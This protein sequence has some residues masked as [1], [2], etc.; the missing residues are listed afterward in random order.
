[1]I[2]GS[3]KKAPKVESEKQRSD[4]QQPTIDVVLDYI[5]TRDYVG[6]S[7]YLSFLQHDLNQ[8]IP[9]DIK[10]WEGYSLFHAGQ[11]EDAI[12]LYQSLLQEDPTDTTLNL[13]I[14]SCYFYL[15]EYDNARKFAL[16]GPECDLQT[17]LIFHIAQQRNDEEELLQ[18]HGKLVGTLENQLSLA[19]IHYQHNNYS[20]ALQIYQKILLQKPEYQAMNVYMA[21]CEFKLDQF[22]ESNDHVD[23]YLADNSDSA[24]A[25]NLKACDYFRLFDPEI[26]ESQL[27]QIHKFASASYD[28][29]S[30]L[31]KHNL[32]IFHNGEEGFSILP[33]ISSV[34]PEARYNLG[35]LYMR[36]DEPGEA[37]NLL[38]ENPTEILE[39]LLRGAALLANGQKEQ[40][41]DQV[42]QA[43][44]LFTETGNLEDVKDTVS[45]RTALST[46]AF[47]A[48]NY[49][50]SIS[51]LQT[52]EEYIGT[53]D[54]YKYNI[55]MAYAMLEKWKEAENYLVQVQNEIFTKD[56]HYRSALCRAMI[57][58]GK[59]D[60][61]W[62]MYVNCTSM[63]DSKALLMI[64]STDCYQLSYFYQSMRAF[65]V[66]SKTEEDPI[67]RSGL[68]ASAV[69]VFRS[70]LT[71]K[72][73][74]AHL[75]DVLGILSSEPSAQQILNTIQQYVTDDDQVMY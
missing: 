10:L 8:V 63:E 14:S 6:A 32:C 26:A 48:G 46:A 72:E 13:Y 59:P 3:K 71:Q 61:A 33:K 12:S 64:I 38:S 20:D 1:M 21:M 50:D 52:V 70:V 74:A 73:S 15:Q 28:F 60:D 18:A 40:D 41:A 55:G 65:D 62:Q 47:L 49:D 43:T 45:G 11:Y 67:Y 56:L 16:I 53:T 27:L 75:S 57:H 54:E 31:V 9:R 44:Q 2:V 19:A 36:K 7:T 58:N 35:V 68:I 51:I 4:I 23:A 22:Q 34:L 30:I 24:V 66:L 29:A 69:G 42:E 5:E 17:R 39:L 25:L 37:L